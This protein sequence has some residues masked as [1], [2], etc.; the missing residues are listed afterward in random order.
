MRRLAV[1]ESHLDGVTFNEVGG[2]EERR[3]GGAEERMETLLLAPLL[4]FM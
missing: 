3:R 4:C 1:S 2:E